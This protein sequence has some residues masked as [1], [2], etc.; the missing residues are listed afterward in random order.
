MGD[1]NF[2]AKNGIISNK[3][4]KQVTELND[5]HQIITSC[6]RVTARSETLIDHV[7]ATC[8]GHVVESFVP[9]LAVSDHYPVCFI[10]K[11]T[12]KQIKRGSHK[13]ITYRCYKRFNDDSFL[14][15]LNDSLGRLNLM[16]TDVDKIFTDWNKIFLTVL[17]K[18]AP[19]KTTRVKKDTQPEWFNDEIKEAI[20]KRDAY[21]K[22]KDWKQYKQWRNN[23]NN[24]KRAH[25]KD[26]FSKAITE[27]KDTS[28]LWKHV[29]NI[30]NPSE[31]S[32]LPD[33]LITG[34]KT[35][36][37][38]TDVI[39]NLNAFFANISETIQKTTPD[40]SQ[41][42]EYD[43]S[44]LNEHVNS[45][46]PNDVFFKIPTLTMNNLKSTLN[47]LD[48][49]KATGLDGIS[50]RIL[51][52]AGD[53]IAPSLL[54]M[55]NMSFETGHF[56][57]ILKTAKL[58]PIHKSGPKTDPSNYRP[59]S[60]IPILSKV[61][62]K[63]VTKHLFSFLNKYSILH[64][65]QS[66][67]RKGHSCNTA[68]I[69]LVDKWFKSI[70]NGEI[71]GAVFFDLKKAFDVVDHELLLDKLSQYKF[72]VTSL[73]WIRSYL[74][75]RSQCIVD[76]NIT[77]NLE[78]VKSG[79]PQGSV[80][81]PVLFLLFINDLPLFTTDT[82]LD[83]YADDTTAHTSDKDAS[84][85]KTKLQSGT[86]GFKSWCICN[87]MHIHLKKTCHMMLGSQ[88]N[89]LKTDP[90]EI[91]LGDE[92]IQNVD[93]Q[94]L[95][96][97]VIDNKLSWNEQIDNVCLNISRRITLL[98]LLSKYVDQKS[99]N[100]YYNSYILPIFDCGCMIWGRCTTANT[101]RLLKL[102]KRAARIILLAD[103]LTPSLRMFN[104]LQ[105]LSF[106]RRVQ[107]HS[108][109]MVY[110]ALNNLAPDYVKDLF[111]NVSDKHNRNTRSVDK[112][113]LHIPRFKTNS[114]E[115]SFSVSAAR[116]WNTI[117]LEVRTSSN[118]ETFKRSVKNHLMACQ[119]E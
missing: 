97:V 81:G 69:N 44:K 94:K 110:K 37:T 105:W 89:L 19:V 30:S 61:I 11:T 4:W 49:T 8:P 59:I 103:I 50:P 90:L 62:E 109:V 79:V 86:N 52:L 67:F 2:D 54:T 116:L 83:I 71:V 6:T 13:S 60:I 102:Q 32:T 65:S 39:N 20:K 53:V 27:N 108:C 92:L 74:T 66:G 85:V 16:S 78:I 93:K 51:K 117:P 41:S 88:K 22:N 15:E 73:S 28:H 56:P 12:K 3:A 107:Y 112:A 29:K 24:L 18:H 95:L 80:L 77:S 72:N 45:R 31:N 1:I 84:V 14:T 26:F 76:R 118:L 101:Q 100:Q 7:Y 63:H 58:R 91:Y 113:L 9:H 46:I 99:M 70:D 47:S 57:N 68:L 115:N 23:V 119:N 96:G 33:E 98:K 48:A 55:I 82:E 106:P 75:N 25:K 10:R 43:P 5:L 111:K 114:F 42:T 35:F 40:T 87:K 21:H 64:K 34:D 104:E 36:N 17:D 38:H